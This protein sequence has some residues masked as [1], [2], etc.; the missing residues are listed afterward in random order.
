MKIYMT[1]QPDFFNSPASFLLHIPQNSDSLNLLPHHWQGLLW[2]GSPS[3]MKYP[4]KGVQKII[5]RT[6]H[7]VPAFFCCPR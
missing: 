4:K 7:N 3:T 6:T 1:V 2:L 5:I